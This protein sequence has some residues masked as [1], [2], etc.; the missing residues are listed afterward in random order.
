MAT[1]I[2]TETEAE[3]EPPRDAHLTYED[4]EFYMEK[5]VLD[6][7]YNVNITTIRVAGQIERLEERIGTPEENMATI[8]A[9]LRDIMLKMCRLETTLETKAGPSAGP[10]AGPMA[11]NHEYVMLLERHI[12]EYKL[13]IEEYARNT[14]SVCG[15]SAGA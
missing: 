9:T 6:T 3:P 13:M 11:T 12:R 4:L 2:I 5:Q 10:S 8:M 14:E 1:P 15:P 7:L